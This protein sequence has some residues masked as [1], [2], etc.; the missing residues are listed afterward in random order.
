MITIC[1]GETI[2]ARKKRTVQALVDTRLLEDVRT[3]NL[4]G[5]YGPMRVPTSTLFPDTPFDITLTSGVRRFVLTPRAHERIIV[6][7]NLR[8]KGRL[9]TAVLEEP[10]DFPQEYI[11]WQRVDDT[12]RITRRN[13]KSVY[14]LNEFE[15]STR[16]RDFKDRPSRS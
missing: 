16:R 11:Q 12:L 10:F 6:P 5:L 4:E 14:A 15:H 13:P 3:F 1:S 7:L 9:V 2:V 8:R